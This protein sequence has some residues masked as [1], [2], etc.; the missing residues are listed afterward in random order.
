M[1]PFTW[2]SR[3]KESEQS[4]LKRLLVSL[5]RR[6]AVCLTE[7]W[8]GEEF[9]DQTPFEVLQQE[10]G[11]VC[12]RVLAALAEQDK[13]CGAAMASL[14]GLAIGDAVGAPLEFLP[15]EPSL[16]ESDPLRPLVQ[17]E[18]G[19]LRY[20]HAFNRFRL[21]AGQWTDDT[22]MALCLA[23][24]LLVKQGYDGRDLRL[25]WH[26]WWFHGYCNAFRYDEQRHVRSSVGLGGNVAK[27]LADLERSAEVA[28]TY[29]SATNDA[30][31]GS[32]M[33]LAPVPIAYHPDVQ[34]AM[35]KAIL[36]SRA[37]HPSCD[38]AACCAFMCFFQVRA[39]ERHKS[40]VAVDVR[41][42]LSETTES[43]LASGFEDLEEFRCMESGREDGIKRITA[44]L[45]C[46]PLSPKEANWDWKAS[47]PAIR[48]A[49]QARLRDRRYN[50]HPII[51]TY[52]GAYCMD[53]LAVAL[54][55][56][57]HSSS[58]SESIMRVVN[59]LGDA[60]TTGAICG[61]LAGSFY[62]WQG[63]S[64]AFSRMRLNELQ[65]WDP[66]GEIGLRAALLFHYGPLQAMAVRLIQKEGHA[67]VRLF[68]K[69]ENASKRLVGEV[70]SGKQAWQ[71]QRNCDFGL[72]VAENSGQCLTGWVGIKNVRPYTEE[73]VQPKEP[74]GYPRRSVHAS[75]GGSERSSSSPPARR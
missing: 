6:Q 49:I 39:I 56:L 7:A 26:M 53:G 51:D 74:G 40:A 9:L 44:L 62:G 54:W 31:N 37:S 63:L 16:D 14:L 18:H 11:K 47:E 41:R 35:R 60:D 22:S 5:E 28:P 1:W 48:Q 69:A 20:R 25:R 33:R 72:I 75:F 32:I 36:Q 27:S 59:V 73:I 50:G 52:W 61:Q 13:A 12:W 43:F 19:Q 17:V 10:D 57:W 58:F 67:T 3:P 30:G 2:K 68:D 71:L 38:A 21:K 24:S 45:R 15:V 66:Y 42:F 8:C 55:A 65:Q 46:Q 29:G 70:K 34:E 64:D 4:F 23:D